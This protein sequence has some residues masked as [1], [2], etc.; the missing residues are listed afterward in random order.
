MFGSLGDT[1][2]RVNEWGEDIKQTPE[3]ANPLYYNWFDPMNGRIGTTDPVK[4][5]IYNLFMATEDP[6]VIP[7]V[8]QQI[9]S[10]R[11]AVPGSDTQIEIT[12]EEA[13]KMMKQL[14]TQ[15]TE[16]LGG[17]VTS[18]WY[19]DLDTESK[20]I[21]IK[22]VYNA[23]SNGTVSVDGERFNMEWYDYKLSIINDR[24]YNNQ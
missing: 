21:L 24:L 5:E 1:P 7:N 10:R 22:N 6:G 3:G 15:R 4:V 18:D 20:V 12:T 2:I 17:L 19:K 11:I 8:P 13:N 16:V 14:G 9:Q 23:F